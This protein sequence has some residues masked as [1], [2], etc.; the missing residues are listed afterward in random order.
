MKEVRFKW[1]ECIDENFDRLTQM[2]KLQTKLQ[3][4]CGSD[5]QRRTNPEDSEEEIDERKGVRCDS[6]S[7][8][9]FGH[10]EVVRT[11]WAESYSLDNENVFFEKQESVQ[12]LYMQS[13]MFLEFLPDRLGKSFPNLLVLDAA[14]CVIKKINRRNFQGLIKLQVLLLKENQ[15]E[16]ISSD[17]FGNLKA[18]ER[19]DLSKFEFLLIIKLT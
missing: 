5:E 15:I 8:S 7:D 19:I 1:N 9:N 17:T 6:I 2:T 3:A 12:R 18:I 13:G 16:K 4:K 11:C 10:D 14:K